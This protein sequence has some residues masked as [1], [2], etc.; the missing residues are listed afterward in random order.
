M[1]CR[2]DFNMFMAW[3]IGEWK[4]RILKSDRCLSGRDGRQC[5]VSRLLFADVAVLYAD[6]EE[7]LRRMVN[8]I[9]VVCETRKLKVHVKNGKVISV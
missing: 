1:R 2:H 4:A 7:C 6:G 9:G 3:V 8:E 5:S